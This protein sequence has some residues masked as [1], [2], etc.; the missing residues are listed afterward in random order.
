VKFGKKN[1]T[2][3]KENLFRTWTDSN[4]DSKLKVL[5][6]ASLRDEILNVTI[7]TYLSYDGEFFAKEIINRITVLQ[8]L[9]AELPETAS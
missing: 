8:H 6:R 3:R 7:P 1:N 5:C 2:Y 9:S 4:R